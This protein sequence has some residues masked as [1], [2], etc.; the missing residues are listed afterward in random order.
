[1]CAVDLLSLRRDFPG[2]RQGPR[3]SDRR[4]PSVICALT[5]ASTRSTA[6]LVF[7]SNRPGYFIFKLNLSR[8]WTWP[9]HSYLLGSDQ[10][11]I[12]KSFFPYD[13]LAS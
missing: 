12:S 13:T 6:N 10:A 1:M 5:P 11:H 7:L 2:T 3:E 9:N 4:L 8:T